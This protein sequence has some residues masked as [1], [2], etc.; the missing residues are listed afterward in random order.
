MGITKNHIFDEYQN[1]TANIT[2]VLGHPARIAIIQHISQH[3]YC[4]CN[5]LVEA[6]GLAQPTV[7]QHLS[8]IKKIHLLTQKHQGKN[9]FYA[10]DLDVLNQYRRKINDFFVKIQ[11]NCQK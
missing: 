5:D 6:T 1:E 2:K 8:E 7:S 10:I 9:I 3:E 4:N 11:V